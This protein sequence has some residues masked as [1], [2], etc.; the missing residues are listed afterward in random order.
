[1]LCAQ[2]KTLIALAAGDDLDEHERA[3]V[4]KHLS[5]CEPCRQHH[6][7]LVSLRQQLQD[8]SVD[9]ERDESASLWTTIRPALD[10]EHHQTRRSNHGIA[11][12][13]IAALVLAMIGISRELVPSGNH[14]PAG[15]PGAGQ[16]V[17][18][19]GRPVRPTRAPK[20]RKDKKNRVDAD[21][22]SPEQPQ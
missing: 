12:L 16:A 15:T 13:A 3:D 7:E 19:P 14:D 17:S 8:V 6:S 4:D 22:I 20:T 10:Q 1:M 21:A 9:T 11:A 2:A 5:A 18:V